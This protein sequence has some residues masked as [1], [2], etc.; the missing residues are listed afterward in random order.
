M[1]KERKQPFVWPS[2]LSKLIAGED[3]CFWKSWFKS[4]FQNYDK[5]PSTF[6][7]AMWNVKHTRILRNRVDGL[8]KLGHRV[9]I[10]D[11]NSFKLDYLG[12]VI[13][14]K[15]DIVTFGQEES[16]IKIPGHPTYMVEF[17]EISDAKSGKPKTS[18][19]V[20]IWIYQILLPLAI[21]EYAKTKFSGCVVYPNGVKNVDI[22]NTIT[23]DEGQ[24]NGCL[25]SFF[26]LVLFRFYYSSTLLLV[27]S[28][29]V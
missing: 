16:G 14:G 7:S 13:S 3:H 20:Q 2:W 15:P 6:D 28:L 12:A 4:H 9:L 5:V 19:S 1:K 23:D 25:R 27:Y 11:Q 22:P 10:E 26:I 18:D 8:I 24:T 29:V 21:P 17:A